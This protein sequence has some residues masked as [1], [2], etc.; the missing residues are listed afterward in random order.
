VDGEGLGDGERLRIR[1]GEGGIRA[2]RL[3]AE[4]IASVD[5][6]LAG[7][8]SGGAE[9]LGGGPLAGLLAEGGGTEIDG[10]ADD[11]SLSSDA[12]LAVEVDG[13]HAAT[14]KAVTTVIASTQLARRPVPVRRGMPHADTPPPA[15]R[16]KLITLGSRKG[17]HAGVLACL[18]SRTA[19]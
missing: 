8:D 2:A 16:R 5:S 14:A 19:A 12:C 17:S 3:A 10:A 1:L 9:E 15:A 11:E 7:A 6:A 13:V 18:G 4:T